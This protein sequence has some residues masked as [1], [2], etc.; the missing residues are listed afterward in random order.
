MSFCYHEMILDL[1]EIYPKDYF[2]KKKKTA[3]NGSNLRSC[4]LQFLKQS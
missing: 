1:Y 4:I 3:L 2:E